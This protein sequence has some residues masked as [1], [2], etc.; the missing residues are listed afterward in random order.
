MNPLG[1][2]MKVRDFKI[3]DFWTEQVNKMMDVLYLEYFDHGEAHLKA[4]EYFLKHEEYTHFVYLPDD[5]VI[6]P[7]HV[8]LLMEDIKQLGDNCVVCGYSNVDFSTPSVNI[9]FRDLRKVTVM[10]REQYQHPSLYDI[11]SDKFSY[12]FVKVTFQGNTLTIIPRK[13]VE[14]LSFKPYKTEVDT[15]L[16]KMMIR[17]SMYDLQMCNELLDLR[18]DI[19][20]DLRLL[21]MHFGNTLRLINVRG[22]KRKMYLKTKSGEIKDYIELPPY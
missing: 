6:T 21:I 15:V 14:K 1:V 18:V 11:L 12:P 13:I 10:F 4:R 8:E 16:G 20:C 2:H 19:Y 17:G 3:V 7:S 9:S 22:K 5:V